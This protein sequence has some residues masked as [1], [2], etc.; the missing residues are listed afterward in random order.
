MDSYN[1][2]DLARYLGSSSSVVGLILFW[3]GASGLLVSAIVV[4][5]GFLW[6]PEDK[7]YLAIPTWSVIAAPLGLV[8]RRGSGQTL[9]IAGSLWLALA[10]GAIILFNCSG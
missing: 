7:A 3:F 10:L 1:G 5:S 2:R 4:T 6:Q 8:L 9:F